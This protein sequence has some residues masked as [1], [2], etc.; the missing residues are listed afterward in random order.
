MSLPS[1]LPRHVLEATTALNIHP[2][3]VFPV[4]ELHINGILQHVLILL[5]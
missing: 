5:G 1:W 4:L 3:F 2:G